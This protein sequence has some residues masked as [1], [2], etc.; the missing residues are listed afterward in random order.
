MPQPPVRAKNS[1][2]D[3]RGLKAVFLGKFLICHH[4]DLES[5]DEA[6]YGRNPCPEEHQAKYSLTGFIKIKIL[7]AK[8][9]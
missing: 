2:G 3:Q 7:D 6:P 1:W 5:L 9:T 4:G 8:A